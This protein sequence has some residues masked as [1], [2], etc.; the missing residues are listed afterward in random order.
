MPA[1]ETAYRLQTAVYWAAT[2][3]SDPYG[4]PTVS[5]PVEIEVRWVTRRME[6]ADVF[7]NKVAL[8]AQ[9]VAAQELALHS[10]LW[11]GELAD[12]YGTGSEGSD[13]EVYEVVMFNA[14]P[15]LKARVTRYEAGLARWQDS[16]SG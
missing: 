1:P 11:L 14:T 8:D 3:R 9:V 7:G 6:A 4:R 2:G 13:D 15:D 16:P 12:W 10:R 5:D